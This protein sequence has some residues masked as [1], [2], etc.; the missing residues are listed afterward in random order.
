MKRLRLDTFE[1][2]FGIS[3]FLQETNKTYDY[4]ILD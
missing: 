2:D 4:L 1:N 3:A